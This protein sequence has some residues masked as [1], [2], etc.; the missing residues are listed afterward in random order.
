MPSFS[1]VL[2]RMGGDRRLLIAGTGL[3]LVGLLFGV[4]RYASAPVFVPAAANVS[5]ELSGELVDRLT[6]DGIPYRLERGGSAILV[7]EE[8]LA[9]ARVSLARD[10][11]ASGSRPGL[12]LFDQQ[13]WGW[14]DFTQR[15][16]YRRALEGELERTISRIGGVEHA[17]V[18]LAIGERSAFRR[19]D[20]RAVTA[21]VVLAM[22]NGEAPSA[23][24]VRGMAQLISSSVDGLAAENV[25]VHDRSGRLWTS[26][27]DGSVASLTERQLRQQ[28]EI[29][30]YLE[31]KAEALVGDIV[32]AGNARVRVAATLN[33]DRVE[34]TTQS[35]DPERQ[36]L[37]SEQK[38]EIIPG[39]EGGAASTNTAMT[40]ENTR[41]TEV[42]AGAVG[43]I[44][45][46]TVAVLVND[47]RLPTASP[48]DSLPR[49]APRS[50]AEL[51]QLES[52]V[53]GAIGLDR[54]RGDGITVVNASFEPPPVYEAAAPP[55]PSIGVAI[56]RYQ[57]PA[58]SAAAVFAVLLVGVLTLRALRVPAQATA[59]AAIT[60]GAGAAAAGAVAGGVPTL[61]ASPAAPTVTIPAPR[62]APRIHFASADTQ[63]RDR[64]VQTVEQNP[65]SAARLVKSWIKEG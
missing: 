52:L 55:P 63:V 44:Q 19:S 62:P 25:S 22:R 13:T 30:G 59:Q 40:Y 11:L 51:A 12:E 53:S 17:S 14:N 28:K 57:R 27:G 8:D 39:E 24:V 34:R 5:L 54:S 15:V 50:A 26:P 23:E 49:F 18:H 58:L 2:A 37:A 9:R 35:V 10:G 21:S 3:A 56:E 33:F 29:E 65:D 38:A 42:F 7:A 60:A 31:R 45:R 64:V 36:V 20:Q 4:S 43:N 1:D 48:A 16:N 32:G 6:E 41:S 46:L 61:A 47:Q